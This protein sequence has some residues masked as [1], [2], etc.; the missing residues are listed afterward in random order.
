MNSISKITEYLRLFRL[1]TAAATATSPLLAGLVAGQRDISPLFILFF[2]GI[3]YH[4]FGFVLNEYFDIDVDKKSPDL[5]E[6][7]LVS[8]KIPQKHALSISIIACV[9][10]FIIAGIFFLSIYPILFLFLAF[11]FGGLYDTFGKKIVGSDFILGGAFFFLCLFGASTYSNSFTSIVYTI[12]LVYFIQIVFNNSVE[13]GLKDIDHDGLADV[14]TLIS[15]MGVKLKRKQLYFNK[16]F[17]GFTISLRLIFIALIILLLIQSNKTPYSIL[18]FQYGAFTY[19]SYVSILQSS[20]LIFL[21]IL[22]FINLYKILKIK[23][24]DRSELKKLFS[25][26]EMI[27]YA[28]LIISLATLFDISI[29]IFLLFFPSI[30]YILFNF[31]LYKNLLQPHV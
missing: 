12:S 1:Q 16:T 19:S 9:I 31:L 6:K 2:I 20:I 7:P 18:F 23:V 28:L 11:L 5:N 17:K 4:I 24:F 13:G 25:V 22:L 26:H 3:L 8:G 21:V 14:K 27:S 30:W 10:A 29:T 15:Y